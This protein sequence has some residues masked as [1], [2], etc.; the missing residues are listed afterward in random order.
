MCSRDTTL[1]I[2]W[3]EGG[4]GSSTV[5]ASRFSGEG[6]TEP[7]VVATDTVNM[8]EVSAA[9]DGDGIP[10]AAWFT[11]HRGP[12]STEYGQYWTRRLGGSWTDP[13]PLWNDT[14]TWGGTPNLCAGAGQE[15]WAIWTGGRGYPQYM[16]VTHWDGREWKAPAVLDSNSILWPFTGVVTA[17]PNGPVRAVWAGG[18]PSTSTWTGDSW[19][20]SEY[21]PDIYGDHPSVCSDSA[22]GTWVSC[23]DWQI[24]DTV[25]WAYHD[26]NHWSRSG[27]LGSGVTLDGRALC[28]DDRGGVWATWVRRPLPGD[29]L[30]AIQAA[31]T[32]GDSWSEPSI[33]Q[34]CE[35]PSAPQITAARG[36]IWVSWTV[37]DS[38]DRTLLYYSSTPSV[39]VQESNPRRTRETLALPSIVKRGATVRLTGLQPGTSIEILD[40][41]GRLLRKVQSDIIRTEGL[42]TG[43]HFVR[44]SSGKAAVLRK[45][46]VVE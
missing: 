33:L 43:V 32:E 30:N 25:C 16:F 41:S 9:V 5:R 37:R 42:N 10:W 26:G 27:V 34:L 18:G 11:Y 3:V 35:S 36:R 40:A 20:R 4:T 23:V 2:L 12:D 15:M 1:W 13:L 28:C 39:G 14:A 8:Y 17:P 29:S 21:I 22:G 38:A 24:E 6:W 19:T 44:L 31:H 46:L 7:E 45:L